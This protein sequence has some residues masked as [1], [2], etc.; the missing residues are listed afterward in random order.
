MNEHPSAKVFFLLSYGCDE[1]VLNFPIAST[2]SFFL[3]LSLALAVAPNFSFIGHV[4]KLMSDINLN[5]NWCDMQA[6]GEWCRC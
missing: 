3:S 6:V 1:R 4:K 2:F 5:L